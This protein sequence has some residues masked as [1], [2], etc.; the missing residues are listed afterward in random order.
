MHQ[1]YL[2]RNKAE[3]FKGIQTQEARTLVQNL[4][5]ST[6]DK[7]EKC[8]GRQV[9]LPRSTTKACS[10]SDITDLPQEQ[11]VKLWRAIES[12]PTMIHIFTYPT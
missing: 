12:L 6:P 3:D 8:M 10:L 1:S 9:F 7:Y 11:A 5:E 4:F 2:N